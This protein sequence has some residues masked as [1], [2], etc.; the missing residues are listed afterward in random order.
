MTSSPMFPGSFDEIVLAYDLGRLADADYAALVTA[1][2]KLA[3]ASGPAEVQ[4]HDRGPRARKKRA[5]RHK[6]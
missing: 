4:P 5:P 1:P 2:T 3:L 6:K